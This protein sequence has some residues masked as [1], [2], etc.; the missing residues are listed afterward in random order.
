[1]KA[2]ITD[3][4]KDEWSERNVM[5]LKRHMLEL[6]GTGFVLRGFRK[7]NAEERESLVRNIN[8]SKIAER[9]SNVP[10]PYLPH[11]AIDWINKVTREDD[12]KRI[13]FVID[14]DGEVAGSIAFINVE[15]HKAQLSYWLGE[16][17]QGRGIMTE[18]LKLV[19]ELGFSYC[20][21][22]RIWGY[23]SEHNP[24]SEK[25]LR[26]AGFKLEGVHRKEWKKDG[27]YHDAHVFAIVR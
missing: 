1:M 14:V 25:V 4:I 24:A 13:D 5:T 16:K 21:F 9:V 11:H 2:K 19:V 22:L 20:G 15:G 10:F 6:K 8:S 7:N 18:A 27:I 17:Y 12:I 26:K 3:D 23:I